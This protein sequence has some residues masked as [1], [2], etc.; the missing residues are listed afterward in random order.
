VDGGKCGGLSGTILGEESV[1]IGKRCPYAAQYK[2]ENI[3][4]KSTHLDISQQM[5]VLSVSSHK[6]SQQK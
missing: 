3:V 5:E 1:S 2:N 4:D 6:K